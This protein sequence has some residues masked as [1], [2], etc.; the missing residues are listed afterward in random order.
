[1]HTCVYKLTEEEFQF[2][3]ASGAKAKVVN[4]LY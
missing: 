4:D 2:R 3:V 1:M